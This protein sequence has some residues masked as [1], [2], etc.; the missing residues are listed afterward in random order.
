MR[1]MRNPVKAVS[2]L[3][4]LFFGVT[5]QS[6]ET[7]HN[8]KSLLCEQDFEQGDL[9]GWGKEAG[10]D[11][12]ATIVKEPARAGRYAVRFE[13]RKDDPIVA[14]SKRSEL[15]LKRELEVKVERWYG[16]SIFL[17]EDYVRDP[18]PEIVTQWHASPDRRDGE[19]WRSPPLALS[20]RDG[21][22]CVSWRWDADR[23]MRSN[24]PDGSKS[25]DLG[26]YKTGGWTDWVFHIKWS[27]ESDGLLEVWKNGEK[28]IHYTGPN[29]YNDRNGVYFKTGI[30]KWVWNMTPEKDQS[31]TTKR[32]MYVD[33]VRVGKES[34]TYQDVAPGTSQM[35]G[36][37]TTLQRGARIDI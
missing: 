23:I 18:T 25:K 21:R 24:R 15:T 13:L 26:G 2:L 3:C 22:W 34:A 12:S 6:A 27:W 10:R 32:V 30:Y 16:F 14:S 7:R 8:R 20:T 37:P 36:D 5:E 35:L 33:E 9:S 29:A 11:Y 31:P 4:A 28:V 1:E 19:V 17:P